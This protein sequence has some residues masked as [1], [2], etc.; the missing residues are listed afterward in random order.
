[1][2][3]DFQTRA[4]ALSQQRAEAAPTP[5][6]E[7]FRSRG[8]ARFRALPLPTLKTEA[9]KYTSLRG[10]FEAD[11]LH[12]P[13]TPAP[14][15]GALPD[16]ANR[17][18]LVNGNYVA[19]SSRLSELDGIEC[20]SFDHATP[21]QRDVVTQHLGRIA[22]DA[23]HPFLALNEGMTGNGVLVRAGE[24]ASP[25][26]P[27][28]L[29]H[30][31]TGAGVSRF[32]RVLIV[33]SPMSELTLI[34]H[35]LS[36]EAIDAHTES[37]TNSVTEVRVM[38]GA[39]LVH[40]RIQASRAPSYHI[41][42][43]YADLDRAASYELHQLTLASRMTRNDIRVRML[44][45]GGS[46]VL[47]G[48]YLCRERQHVDNH[49]SIEHCAP[50][51][52]S[53]EDFHGIVLDRAR[54]VFNGRVHIHPGAQHSEAR[55]DNRNLLLS[56]DAE[57]DTKPELEIYADD[58]KCAHGATVGDLDADAMFYLTS[59]GI[60]PTTARSLLVHGFAKARIDQIPNASVREQIEDLLFSRLRDAS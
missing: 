40:C 50:H 39:K 19:Q 7:E 26:Q 48:I 1:V 4:S 54:A 31:D 23:K 14:Y 33:L 44:A 34:E 2:S 35:Y 49:T 56:A 42:G 8:A 12:P 36:S 38:D 5:W 10:L 6:L 29:I 45:P 3:G 9:W 47:N 52:S 37:F 55:L 11:V 46:C 21:S 17:I 51:C 41:A 58:V 53:Q 28:H 25:R 15:E 18:V 43:V 20:V 27:L 57:V 60:D 24:S 16:V 32:A 59:R 22:D 30:V 13:P